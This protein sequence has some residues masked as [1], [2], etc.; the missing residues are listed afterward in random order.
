MADPW[1][2]LLRGVKSLDEDWWV[3][4]ALQ[5]GG[6]LTHRLVNLARPILRIPHLAIH[7]QREMNDSFGPNKETHL[8][9]YSA[10]QASVCV[11]TF[12][13]VGHTPLTVPL[14][15]LGYCLNHQL[16]GRITESAHT[17]FAEE[18]S[19]SL[20]ILWLHLV[21]ADLVCNTRL[22]GTFCWIPVYIDVWCVA[23]CSIESTC[24]HCYVMC[25]QVLCS[26]HLCTLSCD[27][28]PD[29]L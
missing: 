9:V 24:V 3:L 2:Y 14:V 7:L 28:L 21:S 23:K 19:L 15:W 13:P 4:H 29:A 12:W 10:D 20:H 22:S 8:W 1:D 25:C 16:R 18:E 27:V 6:S 11:F 17:L 26:G 5:E